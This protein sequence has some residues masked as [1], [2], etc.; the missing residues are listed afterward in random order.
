[1]PPNYRR[2]YKKKADD[3][4][5]GE[6]CVVIVNRFKEFMFIGQRKTKREKIESKR[7]GVSAQ[8]RMLV[9]P[10][11]LDSLAHAFH[12]FL[13]VIFVEIRSFDVCGRRCVRVVEETKRV[14]ARV[15]ASPLRREQYIN[16]IYMHSR[17]GE[18]QTSEH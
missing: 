13:A 3:G 15:L 8:A 12:V 2:S 17:F 18:V 6:R 10:A 1:M 4:K 11:L 9:V 7:L 16:N 14:R 5:N